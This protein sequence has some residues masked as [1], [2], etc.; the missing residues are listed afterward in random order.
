MESYFLSLSFLRE[1]QIKSIYNELNN[2]NIQVVNTL[3]SLISLDLT[4]AISQDRQS[5]A[6]WLIYKYGRA[7]AGD[8]YTL[9]ILIS[10]KI[11]S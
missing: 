6:D 4:D 8:V 5:R 7:H 11:T 10:S 1:N 2:P 3:I 9:H